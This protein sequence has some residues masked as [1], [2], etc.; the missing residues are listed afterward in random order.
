DVFLLLDRHRVPRLQIMQILLHD[1]VASTR[2]AGVL[3]ADDR[4]VG[5][6]LVNRILGA[7]DKAEQIAF[8]EILKPCTS[9]A[10]VTASPRRDMIRVASS[11]HRSMRMARIWKN[12]SPGVETAWCCPLI[13]RNECRTAGRGFPKNRSHA[14]DPKAMTQDRRPS[15]SWKPAPRRRD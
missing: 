12:R 13:S 6:S 14:S 2:K 1:D 4:R 5:G 9:S 10:V 11:K 8:V 3:A 15:G 7:V